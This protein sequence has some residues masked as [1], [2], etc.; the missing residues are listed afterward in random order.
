MNIHILAGIPK[1]PDDRR[2]GAAVRPAPRAGGRAGAHG[3]RQ[4]PRQS[5]LP[6]LQSHQNV[7]LLTL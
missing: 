1:P 3:V 2:L 7:R 6:T 5:A 4:E